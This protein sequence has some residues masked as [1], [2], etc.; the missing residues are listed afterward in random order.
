MLPI[1]MLFS[2]IIPMAAKATCYQAEALQLAKEAE[3]K[4]T[5]YLEEVEALQTNAESYLEKILHPEK[6]VLITNACQKNAFV[7][8]NFSPNNNEYRIFV[9]L[10]VPKET[11]KSLYQESNAQNIAMVLRGLKE[12]SFKKTAEYLKAL[13]ISVQIDPKLFKKYQISTVPTF[14]WAKENEYH[15]ITGNISLQYAKNKFFEIDKGTNG[16]YFAFE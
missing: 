4:K 15:T 1:L 12:N 11:L 14:V 13:E 16:C 8:R 5:L 9:S 2:L 6:T 7:E 3:Q 10:S